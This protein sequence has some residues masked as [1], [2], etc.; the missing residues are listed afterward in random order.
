[1][2]AVKITLTKFMKKLSNPRN[3]QFSVELDSEENCINLF[4]GNQEVAVASW[5]GGE[6]IFYNSGF[7]WYLGDKT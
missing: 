6:V 2:E 3:F 4:Y 7:S 1:M 5:R